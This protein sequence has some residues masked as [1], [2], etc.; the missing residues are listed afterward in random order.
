MTMRRKL[1]LAVT[2]LGGA[3]LLSGCGTQLGD[4][5]A[6]FG[7][8]GLIAGDPSLSSYEQ[9]KADFAAARYGLAVKRFRRAMADD[10]ASVRSE[11]HTSELQSLMRISYAVFCLKKKNKSPINHCTHNKTSTNKHHQLQHTR[12]H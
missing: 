1:S 2:A 11:E 9:A 12:R 3:L 10:P 5:R 4:A 8:S 7:Y 6:A